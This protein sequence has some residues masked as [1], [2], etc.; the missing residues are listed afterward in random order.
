MEEIAL[1]NLKLINDP[2]KFVGNQYKLVNNEMIEN[3]DESHDTIYTLK[4][5]EYPIYFT[6]HQ[7]INHVHTRY[8][9]KLHGYT[10]EEILELMVC[11]LDVLYDTYEHS[12]LK[13]S[14]FCELLEDLDE[15]VYYIQ[16]YYKYGWCMWLPTFIKTRLNQVCR[17]MIDVGSITHKYIVHINYYDIYSDQESDEEEEEVSPE[18]GSDSEKQD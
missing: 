9:T 14:S 18:E 6:Y 1:N 11:G 7:L 2:S 10:R 8:S 16:Q 17:L 15:K 4:E 13:N 12:D 3:Q 5:L